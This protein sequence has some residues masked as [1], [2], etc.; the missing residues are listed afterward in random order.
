MAQIVE[1][2]FRSANS[3]EGQLAGVDAEIETNVREEK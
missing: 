1:D 2:L 3:V